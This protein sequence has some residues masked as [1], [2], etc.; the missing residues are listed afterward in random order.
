MNGEISTYITD[1]NVF[2]SH[3]VK[4]KLTAVEPRDFCSLTYRHSGKISIS[5]D[6]SSLVCES[7]GITFVPRGVAYN[8]EVIEDTHITAVHFNLIGADLPDYPIVISAANKTLRAIFASLECTIPDSSA[9]FLQLSILYELLHE[10]NK[11]HGTLSDKAVSGK[12]SRAKEIIEQRFC[13]P[14]FSI[15]ALAEEIN[16]STAYLR[17]EFHAAYGASPI[18]H[19]KAMR[20]KR[21]KHLLLTE[22]VSVVKVGELCGYSSTSYFIQDF[23]NLT[24]ESPAQ[25]RNRLSATP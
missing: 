11:N 7:G 1:V 22:K 19:L 25:Y 5:T 12:I 14:V 16:V 20:I 4:N 2:N 13:D 18:K 6:K 23:H 15:D 8:T 21:A 9:R 17:R 24:G 10:L 3:N